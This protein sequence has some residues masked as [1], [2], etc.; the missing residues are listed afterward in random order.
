MDDFQD[1]QKIFFLRV[2]NTIQM[3]EH[4]D[5]FLWIFKVRLFSEHILELFDIFFLDDVKNVLNCFLESDILL[6][7]GHKLQMLL[8][9]TTLSL[10]S[11]QEVYLLCKSRL[12]AVIVLSH[13]VHLQANGFHFITRCATISALSFFF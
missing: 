13:L 2:S 7:I 8:Y 10:N 4:Q 5:K 12:Q 11:F 6:I 1:F 9:F 3:L